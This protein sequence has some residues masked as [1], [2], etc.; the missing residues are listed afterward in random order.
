MEVGTVISGVDSPSPIKT[1]FVVLH[2]IVNR[3][4]FVEIPLSKGKMVCLVTNVFKTNRYFDRADSVKEFESSGTKL[5]DQFPASEW[6]FLVAETRPLG[7]FVGQKVKK[8]SFP[9]S[10]GSKV[11]SASSETL[12]RFF[13]F[14]ENG[15]HLGKIEFHE[16]KVNLDL[17]KLLQK[18]LAVLAMSGAGKSHCIS[19]LIEELLNRKKEDGRIAVIVLDP[20]GEYSSFAEPTEKPFKDYS[21]KTRLVRAEKI[22]IGVSRLTP[23]LFSSIVPGL[24]GAQKRDFARI[25]QGLLNSMKSGNGPFDL[26]ELNEAITEDRETKKNTKIAL[27]SWIYDLQ[28]LNVFSRIDSP[29]L[30]DIVKPGQL[31]IIDLSKTVNEKKKQVIVSYFAKKLFT[32]RRKKNIPPFLL[33]L[34]EAHQFI[35]ERVSG[36]EAVSKNIIKTIAREGRKFGASLCLVSQRPVQLDVTTLSQCN[37]QIIMRITNP[38]DLKHVSESAEGIDSRS[39]SLIT[40]LQVGDALMVGEATGFPLFFSVRQKKSQPNKHEFSLAEEAKNFEE[41]QKKIEEETQEFL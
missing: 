28:S 8:P 22:R 2:G 27:Q 11:F 18:H 6:E 16:V 36:K 34:E 30:V 13:K 20:H 21:A 32:E 38:N 15:L 25:F 19:V 4:Q 24:S 1:D 41:K 14:T 23:Q 33:V 5:F 7:V 37:T 26:K 3:G 12:K 31:T 35:P 29:S 40:S 17:S 9:V 39:L 10:P